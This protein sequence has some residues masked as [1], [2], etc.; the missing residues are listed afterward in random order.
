MNTSHA[1][2]ADWRHFHTTQTVAA[3]TLSDDA[4]VVEWSDGRHS[5]YHFPWLRDNCP[6]PRCVYA[7]T[8]EQVFELADVPADLA[9]QH[10]VSDGLG[11]LLVRW[12][13]GHESRFHP[14]WL[15]AH[16]YDDASRAERRSTQ[17][18]ILWGAERQEALPTFAFDTVLGGDTALH[19]WLVALRDV[20]LTLLRNVPL[21]EDTVRRVANRISFIRESNF[22]VI[23]NVASKPQPDSNAYTSF[24]L[25]PHT[26]LPTRE[27]QP[28]LQFLHCLANDATGGDSVFVDGFAI[29]EALRVQFPADFHTLTTTVVEFRNKDMYTDYRC[30][31]PIIAL[32]PEGKLSEIRFANFLRGPFDV[33]ADRMPALYQAYRC[34]MSLAREARF[35][36]CRRLEA[37]D[38]WVFDNRRVLHARTEFD[39]T[40]GRRHLQGCYVDRDELLSRI[41]ILERGGTTG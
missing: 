33:P 29:A 24:N 22:G 7:L 15:R 3:A 39:P 17:A 32:D 26:D 4:L 16:A 2:V 5:P 20:G 27:L 9:P 21:E 40:S 13:D 30:A 8:R 35:R 28:G 1:A 25:P 31:A 18:A 23:F 38:M 10:A 37:G 11:G 6:C 12:T 14:G 19:A 41:R 36:V 34:F